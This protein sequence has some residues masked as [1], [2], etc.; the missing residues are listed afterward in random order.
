MKTPYGLFTGSP[1][2]LVWVFP[3]A[4]Q[5]FAAFG[6]GG[7]ATTAYGRASRELKANAVYR[8]GPNSLRPIDVTTQSTFQQDPDRLGNVIDNIANDVAVQFQPYETELQTLR[9]K[10]TAEGKT[11]NAPIQFGLFLVDGD[12]LVWKF[13]SAAKAYAPFDL[14]TRSGTKKGQKALKDGNGR[15]LRPPYYLKPLSA[16]EEHA[17]GCNE[18]SR[19]K[20]MLEAIA[21]GT[22]F[23]RQGGVPMIKCSSEAC[24]RGFL[25][26]TS[27]NF[28]MDAADHATRCHECTKRFRLAQTDTQCPETLAAAGQATFTCRVCKKSQPLSE[29][30]VDRWW[31]H[32]CRAARR[33]VE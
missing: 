9:N 15:I 5:A 26:H 30:D 27:D 1:E 32:E 14:V 10:R 20:E 6:I 28:R 31:C 7:V 4:N 17:F 25:L 13:S 12:V 29:K 33:K 8:K 3:S 22:I 18:E 16:E 24:P 23:R 21:N 19:E 2:T 11:K